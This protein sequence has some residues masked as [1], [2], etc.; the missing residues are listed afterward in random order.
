MPQLIFPTVTY[1]H[2]TLFRETF[3]MKIHLNRMELFK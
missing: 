3:I 2:V 1:L